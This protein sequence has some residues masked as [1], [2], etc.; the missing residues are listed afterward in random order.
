LASSPR[1]K[2]CGDLIQSISREQYAG[3]LI[4]ALVHSNIWHTSKL[5]G[6]Y[7]PSSKAGQNV[8][9]VSTDKTVL[10]WDA[11]IPVSMFSACVD[12]AGLVKRDPIFRASKRF[13]V[14]HRFLLFDF[15]F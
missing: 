13:Q 8:S 5:A 4:T 2:Q 11:V 1:T 9:A 3:L 15:R 7:S 6:H 12:F 10:A 14:D